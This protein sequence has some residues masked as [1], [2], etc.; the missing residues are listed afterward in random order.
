M[1]T[2][3]TIVRT[4]L[5]DI[6]GSLGR[7][8]AIFLMI[9]LGVGFFA[10]F[11][12]TEPDMT[13]TAQ[14]YLEAHNLYDFRLVC[15]LGFSESEVDEMRKIPG[16]QFVGAYDTD[17]LIRFP[18]GGERAMRCLTRSD[19]VNLPH[20]TAGR[21][22]EGANECLLD[23]KLDGQFALGDTLILSPDNPEATLGSLTA[24]AGDAYTV[25]GFADS[26]VYLN[27]E[28]GG[29]AI[30]NG[31]LAGIL[32]LNES[33]FSGDVYTV[34]YAD[35]PIAAAAYTAEYDAAVTELS[36]VAQALL[37]AASAARTATVRG[38]IADG[39][40]LL[41]EKAALMDPAVP[42]QAAL[43]ATLRE[44]I[45]ALTAAQDSL[46]A[47]TYLLTRRDNV[48][49]ACFENDKAIVSAIA[50]VFPLLFLLVAVL[51]CVT[52]MARMVDEK[53]GEIGTYR[54]LG[55]AGWQVQM[56]FQLYAAA[57]AV[58]GWAIGYLLGSILI[59]RMLWRV[60]DILYGFTTLSTVFRP[61]VFLFCL[62]AAVG[63]ACIS[64]WIACRRELR[65]TPAELIRPRAPAPGKTVWVERI[66]PLWHRLSFLR[67]VALRNIFRYKN[68]FFMM[69]A[70]V[71]CSAALLITGFGI[72]DSIRDIAAFEFR[73]ICVYDY[74]VTMDPDRAAD[75][76]RTLTEL[77]GIRTG[78]SL[79]MGSGTLSRGDS[80]ASVTLVASDDAR[81][82]DL[83]R[84]HTGGESLPYPAQGGALISV[85]V[86][87]RNGI[88][89]GD[90]VTLR[91]DTAEV[92]LTVSG[93][94][95]NY[96]YEYAVMSPED[97]TALCGSYAPNTAFLRG[98]TDPAAIRAT[99]GVLN[100]TVTEDLMERVDGTLNS[101]KLIVVFV[102]VCAA[103]LAFV[104]VYNLSNINIAER[105][106]EIATI[107]VLG[108]YPWEVSA[109]IFRE[110]LVLAGI[111]AVAGVPLGRLLHAFV[112]SQIRVN[113]V[114]FPNRIAPL[115]YVISV[116]MTL[117]FTA[118]IN[119]VMAR[120]LDRIDMTGS[121]KSVE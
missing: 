44:Q 85:G 10:G 100:C 33:A 30:G 98:Q 109:Y 25:V 19:L 82:T 56:R 66:R 81:I 2:R 29:T 35:A 59:P 63:C 62:F 83:I 119:L 60:Y 92:T 24:D 54:S 53:R 11:R 3:P 27:Y 112:M 72:Y 15:T 37:N 64:T 67:K 101:M 50:I 97:L 84:F 52:T 70:G 118:L 9:A 113:Q 49:Y 18:D 51:V 99:G 77:D 74:A 115:S 7:F 14:E 40:R 117:A 88:R 23:R 105:V 116:V 106:R 79:Y 108:F 36:G 31:S 110:I 75:T 17:V 89:R 95:D 90:T 69:V 80:A 120:R 57:P 114:H 22:P 41:E 87:E 61:G 48:G 42:W 103:L 8:L 107:K 21:M 71:G 1:V 102:V 12:L 13:R 32:Y 39:I 28:R 58:A 20:L 86:A 78:A 38:Q 73:E 5:R 65:E 45:A 96:V 16:W 93:I 104:V 94:F 43:L 47:G 91:T 111:G 4:V 46:T 55:Y 76:F 34:I 6:R 121:L 68:R 26:P